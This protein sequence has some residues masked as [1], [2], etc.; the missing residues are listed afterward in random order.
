MNMKKLN[1]VLGLAAALL[2]GSNV[3]AQDASNPWGIT[4]GAHAVDFTSARGV[5]DGYFDVDDYQIVPPLS[6]LS[7][8]RHLAGRFSADLSASIGFVGA[9]FNLSA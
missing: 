4:I 7:V 5:F 6:K 2:F 3:N 9:S 1:L 8:T